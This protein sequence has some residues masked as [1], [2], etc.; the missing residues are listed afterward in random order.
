LPIAIGHLVLLFQQVTIH[1]A[2]RD[3]SVKV[4]FPLAAAPLFT[5]STA[6]GRHVVLFIL[7]SLGALAMG[8]FLTLALLALGTIRLLTLVLLLI[9]KG[10]SK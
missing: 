7:V 2:I 3:A 1:I 5:I 4:A 8:P 9:H 10:T 6:R